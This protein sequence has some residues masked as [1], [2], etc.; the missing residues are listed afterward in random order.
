MT[1]TQIKLIFAGLVTLGG[2]VGDMTIIVVG[3]ASELEVAEIIA[4]A[5]LPNVALVAGI[6]FFFGHTNGNAAANGH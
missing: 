4:L 6:A 3:I 2:L 1:A 5:G